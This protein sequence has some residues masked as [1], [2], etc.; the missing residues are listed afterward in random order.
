M[1]CCIYRT[2]QEQQQQEQ[3]RALKNFKLLV[4]TARA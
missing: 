1:S 2:N 4:N 3:L